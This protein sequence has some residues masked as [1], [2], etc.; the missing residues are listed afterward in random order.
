MRNNDFGEEGKQTE[1]SLDAALR[2]VI[3][4]L[5]DVPTQ[6]KCRKRRYFGFSLLL[7]A[8]VCLVVAL[9]P[10]NSPLDQLMGL[11]YMSILLICGG[12]HID[13]AA[14][15]E[16]Q[17]SRIMRG[18]EEIPPSSLSRKFSLRRIK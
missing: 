13:K 15:D 7:I 12:W 9:L 8:P 1:K 3:Q 4:D 18:E 14:K 2:A 16:E 6:L 17:I 11:L 10:A 5:P